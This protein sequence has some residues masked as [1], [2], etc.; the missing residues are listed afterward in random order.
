M[1]KN[2]AVS[3]Y[4]AKCR[5]KDNSEYAQLQAQVKAANR[6]MVSMENEINTLRIALSEEANNVT[7]LRAR[8][9]QV[10]TK[11]NNLKKPKLS[12]DKKH[13]DTQFSDLRLFGVPLWQDHQLWRDLPCKK[14]RLSDPLQGE[15]TSETRKRP[16]DSSVLDLELSTLNNSKSESLVTHTGSS[17]EQDLQPGTMSPGWSTVKRWT[18]P[19]FLKD[20]RLCNYFTGNEARDKRSEDPCSL[21]SKTSDPEA[22]VYVG[23]P[24]SNIQQDSCFKLQRQSP[25]SISINRSKDNTET[26]NTRTQPKASFPT[27]KAAQTFESIGNEQNSFYL[28]SDPTILHS[29]PA[30]LPH[31][32]FTFNY[33]SNSGQCH[34]VQKTPEISTAN[35]VYNNASHMCHHK[36]YLTRFNHQH[37]AHCHYSHANRCVGTC[38]VSPCQRKQVCNQASMPYHSCFQGLSSQNHTLSKMC[39]LSKGFNLDTESSTCNINKCQTLFE[40]SKEQTFSNASHRQ[41]H[42]CCTQKEIS[43][44]NGN[45][46]TFGCQNRNVP[47]PLDSTC[48]HCGVHCSPFFNPRRI[49]EQLA[50]HN[51]QR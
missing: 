17:T 30:P 41:E 12:N 27:H 32:P 34:H 5:I 9:I 43:S 39:P 16:S 4:A 15:L 49:E 31:D 6:T 37:S 24:S 29:D 40:K 33:I 23:Q 26:K 50:Y 8:Y 38:N 28:Q 1:L 35:E 14:R 13:A 18:R 2:S 21:S 25:F 42:P 47:C 36:E 19:S 11:L 45:I 7:K 20:D 44:T 51:H 10:K 22:S 3:K 46:I 48:A